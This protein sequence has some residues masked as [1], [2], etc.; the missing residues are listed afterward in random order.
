MLQIHVEEEVSMSRV[1]IYAST[2]QIREK[3]CARNY[4]LVEYITLV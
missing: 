4:L 1:K 3:E 2:L